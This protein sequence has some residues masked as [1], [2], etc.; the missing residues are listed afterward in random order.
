MEE[1]G[2]TIREAADQITMAFGGP[3]FADRQLTVSPFASRRS[4]D[5]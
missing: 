1:L 4:S 3:A 5:G 2:L